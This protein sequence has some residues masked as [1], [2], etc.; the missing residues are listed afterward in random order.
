MIERLDA[1][2]D[3][4]LLMRR[5]KKRD[6]F[7]FRLSHFADHSVLWFVLGLVRFAFV[8]IWQ[9]LARFVLVMAAESAITNGPIKFIFRRKRPHEVEGTFEPGKPLPHG[10]RMPITSSFPSG[11]ATAAMCACVLLSSGNP[12]VGIVLFPLRT[13]CCIFTNVHTDAS[14]VRRAR[15]F[16]VGSLVWLPR[17]DLYSRSKRAFH[18]SRQTIPTPKD[19]SIDC[20]HNRYLPKYT[21]VPYRHFQLV[22]KSHRRNPNRC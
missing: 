10:L 16:S 6:A 17:G 19:L 21:N 13:G 8:P 18:P 3:R 5:T 4:Y 2:G 1:F 22:Q 9:D 12:W 15:W 20:G 14:S 7:W 11:H